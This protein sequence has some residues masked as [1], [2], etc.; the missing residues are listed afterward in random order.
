MSIAGLIMI[1]YKNDS[2]M[3]LKN[4]DFSYH[5]ALTFVLLSFWRFVNKRLLYIIIFHLLNRLARILQYNIQN[6]IFYYIFYSVGA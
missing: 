4:N 6:N 2:S 3:N 5:L 1:V